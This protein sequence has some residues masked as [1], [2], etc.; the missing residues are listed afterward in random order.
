MTIFNQFEHN[1]SVWYTYAMLNAGHCCSEDK[2]QFWYN[3]RVVN[4]DS[5]GFIRS[6]TD[7]TTNQLTKI[8]YLLNTPPSTSFRPCFGIFGITWLKEC[9]LET[10][11]LFSVVISGTYMSIGDSNKWKE[12]HQHH[13]FYG[14]NSNKIILLSRLKRGIEQNRAPTTSVTRFGRFLKGLGG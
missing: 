12:H 5:K 7:E 11:I 14:Y 1:I 8:S 9:M 13:F 4:Y 2:F 3:S 6:V 10:C